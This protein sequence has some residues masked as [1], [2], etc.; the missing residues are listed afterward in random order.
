M[1]KC[2]TRCRGQTGRGVG[3]LTP[4]KYPL[5]G[6]P[7]RHDAVKKADEEEEREDQREAARPA[8]PEQTGGPGATGGVDG[9][10][11]TQV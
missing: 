1:H 7:R 6:M 3:G 9:K 5:L 8:A 4:G 11:N 10:H 2:E